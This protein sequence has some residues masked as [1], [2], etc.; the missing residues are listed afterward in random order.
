M[1][2]AVSIVGTV[3]LVLGLGAYL[4]AALAAVFVGLAAMEL[5]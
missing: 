5:F 1:S 2:A 3:V 4:V